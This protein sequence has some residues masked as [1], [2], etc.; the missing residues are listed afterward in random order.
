MI[1]WATIISAGAQLYGGIK[2]AINN[3]QQQANADAEA[4]RQQAFYNAEAAA[5]PLSRSENQYLLGKFDRDSQRA[6][7]RARAVGA[8]TGATPEYGLA[9]QKGVAD[10]RANMMGQMSAGASQRS[11]RFRLYG[12][13]AAHQKAAEDQQ[14]LAARQ[15]TYANLVQN[16]STAFGNIMAAY[17][18]AKPNVNKTGA[19]VVENKPVAYTTGQSLSTIGTSEVFNPV[20]ADTSG[21]EIQ[22]R[23]L[24]LPKID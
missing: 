24:T 6:V 10:A 14:R 7:E 23:L 9:V 16:A 22:E 8:I 19:A 11:D 18:P 2:S 13:R 20:V 12:E 21:L 15:E 17:Q 3:R 5:N 4:A 1:P